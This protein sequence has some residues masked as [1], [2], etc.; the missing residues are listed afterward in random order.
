[1]RPS[2]R[3]A[4]DPVHELVEVAELLVGS[5]RPHDLVPAGESAV[6][7]NIDINILRMFIHMDHDLFHQVS[8]DLLAIPVGRVRRVPERGQVGGEGRDPRPL[9]VCELRRLFAEEAVVIVADLTLGPQR[10]LPP[11]LQGSGHEAILRVDGPVAPFG[12]FGF[13]PGSFQPLFPVLVQAGPFPLDV[14]QCPATQL[15][16]GGFQGA[17][18]LLRRRDR[19][20]PRP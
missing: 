17:K 6:P 9:L 10:L 12:V 20:P 11:L 1:M 18:N 16:R 19:R 2:W 3:N 5:D 14:L 8:D 7:V 4:D 15:Q 13:V